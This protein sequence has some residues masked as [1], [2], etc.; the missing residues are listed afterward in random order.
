MEVRDEVSSSIYHS[1]TLPLLFAGFAIESFPVCFQNKDPRHNNMVNLDQ[2][3]LLHV[4]PVLR[5]HTLSSYRLV[6]VFIFPFLVL[7]PN[8]VFQL[9]SGEQPEGKMKTGKMRSSYTDDVFI[10][11]YLFS[12]AEEKSDK[13]MTC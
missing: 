3:L 2:S 12:R 6:P 13:F 10:T 7:V 9:E 8:R 11:G 4:S 1:T 5:L